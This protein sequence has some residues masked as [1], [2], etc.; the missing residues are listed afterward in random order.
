LV[1]GCDVGVIVGGTVDFAGVKVSK[2]NITWSASTAIR[3]S[4]RWIVNLY[5]CVIHIVIIVRDSIKLEHN[6][7]LFANTR[8]NE[9]K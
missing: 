1:R 3:T 6:I 2:P 7:V 5:R 8:I 9:I 4:P